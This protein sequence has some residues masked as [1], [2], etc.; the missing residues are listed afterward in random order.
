[1]LFSNA[2][3]FTPAGYVPGGF[4]V[5]GGVFAALY[6]GVREGGADLQGAKVLPG[7]VD[8]HIH[9]A[10]GEDVSDG[11]APGLERMARYLASRGVTAFLPTV[12]TLPYA[13]IERALGAVKRA[14]R[15]DPGDGARILGEDRE[16]ENER[17]IYGSSFVHIRA[18]E[19]FA[20]SAGKRLREVLA[21]SY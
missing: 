20:G 16:L 15:E 4:R 3:I 14:R 10:V 13:H 17:L 12:M 7:L 18:A 6:P 21:Q 5:E 19:D 9:G 2:R 1:M 11:D 8:I